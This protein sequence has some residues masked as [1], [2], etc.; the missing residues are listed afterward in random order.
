MK[1]AVALFPRFTTSP[2]QLSIVVVLSSLVHSRALSFYFVTSLLPPLGEGMEGQRGD[3]PDRREVLEGLLQRLGLGAEDLSRSLPNRA[4]AAIQELDPEGDDAS[5][6]EAL[7]V[8]NT[9]GVKKIQFPRSLLDGLM[10]FSPRAPLRARGGLGT[11]EGENL[12][13]I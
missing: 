6:L 1:P 13:R 7:Q 11:K 10:W 4:K 2:F 8:S 5:Q 3:G 12:L 9:F